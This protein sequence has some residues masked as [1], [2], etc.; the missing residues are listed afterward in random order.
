M[1]IKEFYEWALT[2]GVE[3]FKILCMDVDADDEHSLYQPLTPERLRWVPTNNETIMNMSNDG[4][5][6]KWHDTDEG[7]ELTP[8]EYFD[9]IHL[10]IRQGDTTRAHAACTNLE[11]W[12]IRH[13]EVEK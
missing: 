10:F 5:W 4:S 3:D 13:E 9:A 1:T 11:R 7:A 8:Q 12:Y 6:R 2:H